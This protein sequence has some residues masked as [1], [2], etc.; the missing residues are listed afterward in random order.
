VQLPLKDNPLSALHGGRIHRREI[1]C[2][3]RRKFDANLVRL[4]AL[5][6]GAALN[7]TLESRNQKVTAQ[8]LGEMG[9]RGGG[10]S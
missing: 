6:D 3:F 9:L 1:D 5:D 8:I 7:H 10:G 2:R 4:K